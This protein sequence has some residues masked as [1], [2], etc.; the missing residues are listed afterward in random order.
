MSKHQKMKGMINAKSKKTGPALVV[1]VDI[2]WGGGMKLSYLPQWRRVSGG[3]PSSPSS[4]KE[5]WPRLLPE[6]GKPV[7]TVQSFIM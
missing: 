7:E 5:P 4:S 1:W 6:Q 2:T 3:L